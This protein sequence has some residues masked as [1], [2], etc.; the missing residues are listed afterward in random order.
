ML[1]KVSY[2]LILYLLHQTIRKS[3]SIVDADLQHL[4]VDCSTTYRYQSINLSR[5]YLLH[6]AT[7]KIIEC[8]YRLESSS[9]YLHKAPSCDPSRHLLIFYGALY[10]QPSFY[11]IVDPGEYQVLGAVDD[12]RWSINIKKTEDEDALRRLPFLYVETGPLSLL[13]REQ[14]LLP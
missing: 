9:P 12:P 7:G 14:H 2:I 13:S 1:T 3:K 5:I 4:A 8:I 6:A 10:F 11:P